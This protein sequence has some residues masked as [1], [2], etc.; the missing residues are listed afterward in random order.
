MLA[1]EHKVFPDTWQCPFVPNPFI[2]PEFAFV[3][4]LEVGEKMHKA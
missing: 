1:N 4:Q 2:V 3:F